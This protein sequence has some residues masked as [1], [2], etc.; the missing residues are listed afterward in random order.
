M[1]DLLW[2]VA[3]LCTAIG[4]DMESV[5]ET[6]IKKLKERYPEGFEEEKSLHRKEGDI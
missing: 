2:F 1:G 6:N 4:C 5:M 3:E